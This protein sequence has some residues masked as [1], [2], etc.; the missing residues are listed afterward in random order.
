MKNY[1]LFFLMIFMSF[2]L[3]SQ[4]I[5]KEEKIKGIKEVLVNGSLV[6]N[7]NK[8]NNESLTFEGKEEIIKE[9]KITING[10]KLEIKMP[11][12]SYLDLNEKVIV[13]LNVP[14]I[15]KVEFEGSGKLNIKK[16]NFKEFELKMV[17]SSEANLNE[18]SFEDLKVDINGTGIVEIDG[19]AEFLLVNL[20]GV[21]K[22]SGYNLLVKNA[23]VKINGTGKVE[24]NVKDKLSAEINGVGK[25]IYKGKPALEKIELN[26]L[27]TIKNYE[28]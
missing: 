26:G 20:D 9:I 8:S 16:F 17:G 25:I 28:E 10:N 23:T 14:L 2:S 13:N 21:G 19:K 3:F 18:N 24:V 6:L 15:E 7:L 4:K 27:G 1:L 22:L 5:K 12:K 11:K